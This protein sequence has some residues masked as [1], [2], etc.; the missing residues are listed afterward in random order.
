MFS[1]KKTFALL[2]CSSLFSPE[3]LQAIPSIGIGARSNV[4]A[5]IFQTQALDNRATHYGG[6]LYAPGSSTNISATV[7]RTANALSDSLSTHPKVTFKSIPLTVT[8][9]IF[10]GLG[11]AFSVY[12]GWGDG[13]VF[14]SVFPGAMTIASYLETHFI[15]RA[16]RSRS[17]LWQERHY[18]NR[19]QNGGYEFLQ[20]ALYDP[21]VFIGSLLYAHR[22]ER[23]EQALLE[24]N[25]RYAHLTESHQ[26]ALLDHETH[27]RELMDSSE[28]DKLTGVRN[29]AALDQR[30][31]HDVDLLNRGELKDLSVIYLDGNNFKEVN[32]THGHTVG[33][34]VLKHIATALQ[35]A[36][37]R[38]SDVRS[39]YRAGGDE[40]VVVL[41]VPLS[42]ATQVAESIRQHIQTHVSKIPSPKGGFVETYEEQDFLIT[43]SIGVTSFAPGDTAVSVLARAD[44]AMYTLKKRPSGQKDGVA[45][46]D[47][48]KLPMPTSEMDLQMQGDTLMQNVTIDL[49][50]F[51][52]NAPNEDLKNAV[53]DG[54][55]IHVSLTSYDTNLHTEH[56]IGDKI[57]RL[58]EFINEN[59]DS[60]FEDVNVRTVL[61]HMLYDTY[62]RGNAKRL[63]LPLLFTV[64]PNS[65]VIY[66]YDF[67]SHEG[68][69]LRDG[70]AVLGTYALD[71]P[72]MMNSIVLRWEYRREPVLVNN[73]AIGTRS[74]I[75]LREPL[76]DD[77]SGRS[78][79]QEDA[80]LQTILAL[81]SLGHKSSRAVNMTPIF[82]SLSLQ[83]RELSSL[84]T[85]NS[86][87]PDLDEELTSLRLAF[88]R[89]S[90]NFKELAR[91]AET[92]SEHTSLQDMDTSSLRTRLRSQI[93]ALHEA[94]SR[95]HHFYQTLQTNLQVK[96][97][98]M[99]ISDQLQLLQDD[100]LWRDCLNLYGVAMS[101]LKF[102]ENI[103]DYSRTLLSDLV[104]QALP[105][106]PGKLQLVIDQHAL[107]TPR[108]IPGNP[109]NIAS[110]LSNVI[111]NATKSANERSIQDSIVP[112]VTL[113][114]RDGEGW[115]EVII[116]DNGRGF[117][118][119]ALK[120]YGVLNF[121]TRPDGSG[122]GN[123]E[124]VAALRMIGGT[125]RA[126]NSLEGGGVVTIR[127]PTVRPESSYQNPSTLPRSE[128]LLTGS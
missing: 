74:M 1:A 53:K 84:I 20:Y 8:S 114:F 5:S 97:A 96:A 28:I 112:L 82:L 101:R 85:S 111:D 93:M 75:R 124:S 81:R 23:Y 48:H 24:H 21:I 71:K 50:T 60:D 103:P 15:L 79:S 44:E 2:L 30:L 108:L 6:G 89:L 17:S 128:Q 117:T 14:V 92:A 123:A 47:P 69:I 27:T 16:R 109:Y 95:A 118:Q 100:F 102:A 43:A 62:S 86:D 61:Y 18:S 66:V 88:E 65:H 127:L 36:L 99:A 19:P 120:N 51:D 94:M 107:S 70:A 29:R 7:A 119:E 42:G 67:A 46:I 32:D 121:T 35:N 63:D 54:H 26:Q 56:Q 64:N 91:E 40:F 90:Y 126:E 110:V 104:T 73:V 98:N 37:H 49:R 9:V 33:D 13:W 80:N 83:F 22:T 45:V 38:Q 115:V 77:P 59:I 58:A 72:A 125:I 41:N 52:P 25:A 3:L 113:D 87:N 11:T 31:S 116:S 106:D 55:G 76:V 78:R 57:S 39:V 122:Q 68:R 10:W 34:L 105:S 12:F 4:Q